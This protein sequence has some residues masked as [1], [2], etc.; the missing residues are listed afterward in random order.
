[1]PSSR[2]RRV[3]LASA[4][5]LFAW[6]CCASQAHAQQ[7]AQGFGVERFYP[8]A[9]GG[10]WFVMDALDMHGGLGGT[11]GLTVGYARNPLR[12]LDGARTLDV[13]SHQLF[14]GIG[15][16]VT[17]DRWRWYLNLDAPFFVHGDSGTIG[18]Y[19]FSGPS[20]D[21]A[22]HPDTLSDARIGMDV[23][24][25]GGPGSRFRL[26]AGAQIFVPFGDRAD[27][28]T[29]GTLRAMVRVL[30]A[31][32]LGIFTYAAHVGVH[33]RTLD[34]AP[35]P[36]SPQGSEMLF[37]VAAGARIPVGR[38]GRFAVVVGPEVY[39]ATAFRSFFGFTGTDLEGL[40]SARIEGT[41]PTGMQLRVKLAGGFGVLQGFGAPDWR[42]VIG[43]EAFDHNHPQ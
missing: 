23:R 27:Y 33:V 21:V 35:V 31:G 39:G 17:Y 24:I 7:S 9:P 13:V 15:L 29:D 30:V 22:S 20:V 42:V 16:A 38:T 32:D 34:E 25:A 3:I 11:M 28:V 26:G 8:S 19:A 10:G 6:T 18:G 5:V 1:M 14:A 36:G 12:L 41:R 40:L 37:G 4:V 2:Q 43:I